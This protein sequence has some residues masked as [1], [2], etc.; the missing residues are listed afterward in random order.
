MLFD[1]DVLIWYF[2][3]NENAKKAFHATKDLA[4]SAVTVMELI[5]GSRNKEELR[6]INKFLHDNAVEI[7]LITPEISSQ[8]IYLLETYTLAEGMEWGDALI[9]A[10]A[11]YHGALLLTANTKHYRFIKNMVINK[12]VP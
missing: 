10:T 7:Y 3:G 5:Q 6:I 2:R 4:V 1:T 11:L 9:A 8:A 12:F